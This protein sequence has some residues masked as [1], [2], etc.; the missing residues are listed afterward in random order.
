MKSEKETKIKKE[1]KKNEEA[2]SF[3]GRY[4][5]AV[6]RR[7]SATAE[8]RLYENGKGSVSIN[9]EKLNDYF[10]SNLAAIVVQPIKLAGRAKDFDFSI[11][12]RG[13]GQRGQAEAARH[14][15]SRCLLKFD[16]GLGLSLRA[17]GYLTRD[18]RVKERKKPG[19]KKARRAPQWSKR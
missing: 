6:G 14:G 13:G 10:P 3:D 4:I 1:E 18:A 9:D 16:A 2:V 19:L 17:K 12:V 8:V 11:M 7:K 15:I 5:A